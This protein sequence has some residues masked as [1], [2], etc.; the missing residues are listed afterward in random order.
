MA[1]WYASGSTL[2]AS[3]MRTSSLICPSAADSADNALVVNGALVFEIE[4]S[5]T[6]PI[7]ISVYGWDNMNV[8]YPIVNQSGKTTYLGVAG[9]AGNMDGVVIPAQSPLGQAFGLTS[10][11]TAR[12]FEG[13]FAT[14]TRTRMSEITDGTSN[15]L[16]FGENYGGRGTLANPNSGLGPR[17]I[18][19]T[20][21]GSGHMWTI[22][23]LKHPTPRAKHWAWFHSDHPGIVQFALADGAIKRI[24]MQIDDRSY[25]AASAMRDGFTFDTSKL[26]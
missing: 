2:A 5:S 22:N 1:V 9:L 19:W 17:L 13:V 26:E 18:G 15:T 21:I 23:G 6:N 12:H 7:R 14:R 10:N 16:L 20:W 8:N 3:R 4:P 24:S 11:L 25:F